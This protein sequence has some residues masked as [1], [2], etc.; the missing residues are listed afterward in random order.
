LSEDDI[1]E[2]SSVK[3]TGITS[4]INLVCFVLNRYEFALN[5]LA[6]K[7]KKKTMSRQ[8]QKSLNPKVKQF[9]QH[10]HH[11]H[12]YLQTYQYIFINYIYN[13]VAPVIFKFIVMF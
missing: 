5:P 10:Q 6:L 7:R 8:L 9:L 4:K 11:Q 2:A 1:P 12:Q 3:C 13:N